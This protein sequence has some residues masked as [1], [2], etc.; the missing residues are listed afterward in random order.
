MWSRNP[1]IHER[2]RDAI[3]RVAK[4]HGPERHVAALREIASGIADGLSAD[5]MST[6]ASAALDPTFF[7]QQIKAQEAEKA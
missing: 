2:C 5:W 1:I 3:N 7:R 4:L 6:V